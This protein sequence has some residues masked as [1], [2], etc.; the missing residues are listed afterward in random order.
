VFAFDE[1]CE[2]FSSLGTDWLI[3]HAV[4][5]RILRS[6]FMHPE[7]L[8]SLFSLFFKSLFVLLSFLAVAPLCLFGSSVIFIVLV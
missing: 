3:G 7:I 5:S 8:N 6:D 2:S 4:I 1:L